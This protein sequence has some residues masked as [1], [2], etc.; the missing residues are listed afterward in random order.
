MA[1]CQFINRQL[2]YR[3]KINIPD[4][5]E[6]RLHLTQQPH[7]SPSGGHRGKSRTLK[8]LSRHYFCPGLA[9]LVRRFVRN[10]K[11]CSR[12]KASN[13][14][15]NRLSIHPLPLPLQAWKKMVLDFVT[16]LPQVGEY[17]AI[18]VIIDRLTK[19]RHYILSA[20]TIDAN[21]LA[22]LYYSQIYR[23]HCLLHFITSDRGPQFI[24]EFW[25]RLTQRLRVAL[26][27]STAYHPETDGQT[28]S[29]NE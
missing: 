11:K 28:K 2:F 21:G 5:P 4:H 23:L 26:C 16:G 6:L 22:N 20:D 25:S 27:L 17:N 10:C 24:N 3:N 7:N 15:Y 14:K 9:Q 29:A 19:Q 1:D 18:C 12:S 8:T 13:E